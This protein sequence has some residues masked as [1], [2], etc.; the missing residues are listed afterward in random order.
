MEPLPSELT[1]ST[2]EHTATHTY[3]HRHNTHNTPQ[4]LFST[5]LTYALPL[6][7]HVYTSAGGV[8]VDGPAHTYMYTATR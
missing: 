7:A 3:T 5:R 4:Q 6:H 8:A 1:Q 2:S